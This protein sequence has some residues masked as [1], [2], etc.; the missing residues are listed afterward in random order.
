MPN[1]LITGATAGYGLAMARLFGSHGWS[2]VLVGRRTE[3]LETV[4]TELEGKVK[5]HV[6]TLD[7]TD[8]AAVEKAMEAIPE[9]FA[10]IDALVNNAGL[11]VGIDPAQRGNL[12]DWDVMV[13]TNIKGMFLFIILD[14]FVCEKERSTPLIINCWHILV[15]FFLH[16]TNIC[17]IPSR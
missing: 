10:T 17:P 4:K 3:R 5:V 2:L 8:R 12:D 16:L 9:E 6:V 13:D 11:A 7:V 15:A 14:V 1:I